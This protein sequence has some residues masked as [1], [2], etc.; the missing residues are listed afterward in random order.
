MPPGRT[1]P[2]SREEHR[3]HLI[4][5]EILDLII[6]GIPQETRATSRRE[7]ITSEKQNDTQKWHSRRF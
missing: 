2:D 1:S 3:Q 7:A 4:T 6:E 5:S